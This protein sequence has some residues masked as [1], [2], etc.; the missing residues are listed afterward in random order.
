MRPEPSTVRQRE[1]AGI[2]EQIIKY[3]LA[4]EFATLPVQVVDRAKRVVADE[5][6]CMVLGSTMPPGQRMAAYVRSIGGAAQ[7]GVIGAGF[8]APAALA[9][10]VNGTAAHADELDGVHITQGHPSGT[11]VAGVLAVSSLLGLNGRDLVNGVVLAYDVGCRLLLAVGGGHALRRTH[12]Q[13]S[14]QVYAIGVAAAAARLLRLDQLPAQHALALAAMN[15]FVPTA[16][17]DERNHMSKAMN[18]GQAAFAGVTGALLA[19]EGFE[20]HDTIV[21]AKDGLL[22]V[23]RTE[24]SDAEIVTAG[25]GTSYSIMDAGF[26]Y[27]S[28]GYPINAPIA[29][30]LA[31]LHEHG[32]SP[33]D[34]ARVRV[35][36]SPASADVVDNRTMPSISLQAML[37]LALVLGRLGYDDAHEPGALDRP[38]VRRLRDLVEIVRDPALPADA[39][40][41]R[42]AWVEITTTSGELIRGP[43]RI[44]PGHWEEGGMPWD[45]LHEKFTS[46]VAP[47]L[48]AADA[49]RIFA[50]VRGLDEVADLNE[51]SD[52]VSRAATAR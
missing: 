4:T 34:I 25:L 29:G 6:G 20:A 33:A 45:D 42:L 16:F 32:L 7:A 43:A 14:S 44:A 28:A 47:R 35:G 39:A 10:L 23:W 30:G 40:R 3:S 48:G 11:S 26:K 8:R 13:H 24:T 12:K 5:L 51:L 36:M 27:Y 37:S 49:G 2:T 52:L 21:E 9:A 41:R 22:D 31:I 38:D 46:I 17:Y 15:V 18:Q 50:L 1:P 19:A